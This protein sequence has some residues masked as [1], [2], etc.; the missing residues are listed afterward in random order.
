MENYEDIDIKRILEII[1]S[2]LLFSILFGYAYSYYYKK[3]EYKSSVTIL[4]VA[5]ENKTNKELTQTDL[6]INNGL[7]STYSSIAKSTNVVQK[8]IENLELNMSASSLQKKVDAKQIDSTQFLKISVTNANPE[9]AKNIANELAQV[10]TQQIKE[11]YN[12]QNISIVDEAEVESTPCNVNHMKDII[13]FAFA[14]LFLA[15]V[16]VVA[17]FM[18]DDTIK[19]EEDIE[20]NVKLKAIGTLPVDKEKNELIVKNNPK[21]QIVESI[22]TIRT[23]ILYSTNK[24]AILVTS[25]KQDEGKTWVIN[26]LAV[27]FAQTGKRVILVDANLREESNKNDIF[28]IDKGEGLSDFIKEISEDNLDN[29][30]KSRNYIKETKIPNLHILQ[31]GTIPPNP[32]ELVSSRN[33]QKIIKLLKNMY[34]V[35]LID[36]T[37]S[38]MV[39]DS[40]ALSSMVDSTILIAEN[41]KTKIND[42]KKVKKLIE[43]VHGNILGVILNKAQTQKGKYY[44]KKYGYYYGSDVEKQIQKIEE[45]QDTISLDEVIELAKEKIQMQLP[46]DEILEEKERNLQ[47]E[48]NNDTNDETN[49]EIKKIRQEILG[50]ID[51]IKNVFIEFKRK[52]KTK[53]QIINIHNSINNLKQI[54]ENNNKKLIE[55]QQDM[56]K[57]ITEQQED[58]NNDILE[59]IL[60]IQELQNTKKQELMENIQSVDEKQSENNRKLMEQIQ[61]VDERQNENNQKLIEQIKNVEEKQNENNQNLIEQIKNVEENQ[62]ENNQNL[63]EQ[64]KNVEENQNENN[65]NLIEKIKNVEE[66]QNEN[67]Q[68]LIEQIKNVEEKQNENNQKLIEQIQSVK[69]NQK[70]VKMQEEENVKIF[71][72]Q[73]IQEINTLRSEIKELK[74]NQN[75]SRAELL[76]KI[77]NMKYEEK[78]NEINE[79]LQEKETKNNIISFETLKR[80]KSNKKV[81]NINEESIG[82]EDL[83]RLSNCIVDLNDEVTSL[84]AMSN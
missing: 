46:E 10:F 15:M 50:E 74:D 31:N 81:F 43:D 32:V 21:S 51:K 62:N 4:L 82:F 8:T 56:Y 58:T 83:Q 77:D 52:D 48:N 44:G 33:M 49:N 24:N 3:P 27:T 41:K 39:S 38:I 6:N 22:K 72:E 71:V 12:L 28:E 29:L 45:K 34:D 63:I 47:F 60:K 18:F 65:Q 2:K 36:G 1:L 59:K 17:I 78:L 19:S 66:K 84:E 14:G 76:E 7:I 70:E 73:F 53:K 25:C 61:S 80:K 69:E 5:D 20:K 16:S 13:M 57:K 11:I 67:N 75:V 37:S 35:V 30:Q 54:Q 26:N 42:L 40:I 23:N 64:I 68:N 55:N 79:K 9:L